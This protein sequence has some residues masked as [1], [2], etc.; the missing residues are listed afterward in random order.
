MATE[1]ATIIDVEKTVGEAPLGYVPMLVLLLAFLV[2]TLDGYNYLCLSFAAPSLAKALGIQVSSFGPIFSAGYAGVLV[3]GLSIGALS[4]KLGRKGILLASVAIFGMFSLLPIF[5]LSY[6]RLL[7]YRFVTGLGLGGAMPSAVAL[8]SEYAPRRYRALFVNL[9]FAGIGAGGVV[10]GFLASRL[11]P[12]HGW[13]A[14][15]WLGGIPPLAMLSVLWWL[16]PESITYLAATKR[17]GAYI[18]RMLN[19]IDARVSHAADSIFITSESGVQRPGSIPELFRDGRTSGTLLIWLVAFCS[20]FTF[21]LAVSWLP[22]IMTSEGLPQQ[23]GILGPVILNLG[24]I[25]GTVLLGILFGRIGASVIIASSLALATVGV[26]MIGQTMASL[27]LGLIFISIF[28]AGLCLVGSINSN[29]ALMSAFYPTQIRATGVG[30]AL[31]MGRVGGIIGPY[32]GGPLLAM[33]LGAYGI[34]VIA[35]IMTA[36]GAVAIIVFG[37]RYPLYRRPLRR[38]EPLAPLVA[39]TAR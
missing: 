9:M 8:T 13:Q 19:R 17:K 4:D 20:L 39:E 11:I 33:K 7:F 37:A 5:D 6:D 1:N 28:T 15:F 23:T 2:I 16:M 29:N 10:G 21:G 24:G 35:A 34:F 36:I 18:A 32:L 14:A 25:V 38:Q 12:L 22:A 3:G 31:G 26:F 30:W 27:A